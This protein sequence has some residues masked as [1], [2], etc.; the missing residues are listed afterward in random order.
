ML[1][2]TLF[3]VAPSCHW[4]ILLRVR[5]NQDLRGPASVVADVRPTVLRDEFPARVLIDKFGRGPVRGLCQ[6][7]DLRLGLGGPIGIAGTAESPVGQRKSTR[8]YLW[9]RRAIAF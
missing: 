1:F 3:R 9:D 4:D 5:H 2:L 6:D 8:R 7:A